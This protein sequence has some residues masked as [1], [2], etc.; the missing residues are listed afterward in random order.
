MYQ[1]LLK[2]NYYSLQSLQRSIVGYVALTLRSL[3]RTISP[4]LKTLETLETPSS[5]QADALDTWRITYTLHLVLWGPTSAGLVKRYQ[6]RRDKPYC[7]LCI[8]SSYHSSA[9]EAMASQAPVTKRNRE[10]GDTPP[11]KKQKD[12]PSGSSTLCVSFNKN[13]EKSSIQCECCFG[14][15]HPKCAGISDD[16]YKILGG[17]SPNIMFFCKHV[18]L[19]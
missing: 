14:W 6:L 1:L 16:E 2:Q 12:K 7:F 19:K 15:I 8:L 17:C 10:A 9:S 4:L 3:L 5:C 13:A 18:A 11:G